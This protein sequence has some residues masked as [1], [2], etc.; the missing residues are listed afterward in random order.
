MKT[1][2]EE[3]TSGGLAPQRSLGGAGEPV[4]AANEGET[5]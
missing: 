3:T 2:Q 4:P 1:L 5:A